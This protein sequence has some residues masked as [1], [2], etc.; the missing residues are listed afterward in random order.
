MKNEY[1]SL[2]EDE[3]MAMALR[4]MDLTNRKFR[5]FDRANETYVRAHA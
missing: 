2:D 4:S 5:V 1:G 3:A